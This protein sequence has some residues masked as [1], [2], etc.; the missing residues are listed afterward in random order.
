MFLGLT[1]L[2]FHNVKQHNVWD[3]MQKQITSGEQEVASAE[4][5]NSKGEVVK[6]GKPGEKIQ[7]RCTVCRKV[8]K[9]KS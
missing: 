6:P 1:F 4:E 8:M 9:Q 7:Y 2:H 5:M 3:T